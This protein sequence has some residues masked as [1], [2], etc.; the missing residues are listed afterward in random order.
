MEYLVYAGRKYTIEWYFNEKK[1]SQP[2]NYFEDLEKIQKLKFL[3]LVKRIGDFGVISDK[4]K[5]RAEGDK[6]FAFKPK[7][8][9]FL[10]FFVS[11]NKIIIT[12]AFVKKQDKLPLSEKAR[13][14]KTKV[15]YENRV[16]EGVYYE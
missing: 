4:T 8:D 15:D 11:G 7:P 16:K 2:L 14:L 13:A 3:F 12:N 1:T 10:C 9:R 6:I 5:F